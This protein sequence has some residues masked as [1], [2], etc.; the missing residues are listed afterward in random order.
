MIY[1]MSLAV[2][3]ILQPLIGKCP[4]G[5]DNVLALKRIVIVA[6]PASLSAAVSDALK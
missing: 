5:I 2:V 3:D 4:W 1:V 6:L